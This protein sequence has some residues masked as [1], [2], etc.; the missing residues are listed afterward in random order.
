MT[1]LLRQY[2]EAL[3]LVEK[4]IDEGA[5]G[6]SG[7]AERG[8]RLTHLYS[9]LL[10]K[11]KKQEA[12]LF[13]EASAAHTKN[14]TIEIRTAALF[15]PCDLYFCVSWLLNKLKT[16]YKKVSPASESTLEEVLSAWVPRTKISSMPVKAKLL[17]TMPL[18][19]YGAPDR[20]ETLAAC[21]KRRS[22]RPAS[23]VSTHLIPQRKMLKLRKAKDKRPP[24][25]TSAHSRRLKRRVLTQPAR[26]DFALPPTTLPLK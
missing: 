3:E 23:A 4:V 25:M 19:F 10:S 5:A 7:A 13:V 22:R 14:D 20:K 6:D 8:L 11:L 1:R 9:A 24:S 17:S 2:P 15:S 12:P 26:L 18:F 16:V 21:A